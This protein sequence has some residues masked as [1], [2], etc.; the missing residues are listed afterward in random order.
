MLNLEL[1]RKRGALEATQNA[2]NLERLA[3][4]TPAYPH[5]PVRYGDVVQLQHLSSGLFVGMH[6]TPAPVNP[7]C[8][9]VSLKQGSL[10]AHFRITPRFKVGTFMDLFCVHNQMLLSAS[11]N[12]SWNDG[13]TSAPERC[14]VPGLPLPLGQGALA[15]KRPS[16]HTHTCGVPL[17]HRCTC[18]CV[19]T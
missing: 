19:C 10:A 17:S 11:M 8:R 3:N 6:K 15:F 16:T 12:S 14:Q 2:E 5:D 9:R 1:A 13:V 4:R 7:N 18:T